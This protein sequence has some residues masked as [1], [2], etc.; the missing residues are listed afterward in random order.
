MNFSWIL[1]ILLH[2]RVS[3]TINVF[4]PGPPTGIILQNTPGLLITRC[5]LYTQRVYVCLDPWDVY[6][7][8]ISLPPR[9]TEGRPSG[10]QTHDTVERA[11]QTTVN[12]LEQLQKFLQKNMTKQQ[13]VTNT[14]QKNQACLLL[15]P[16][17][18]PEQNQTAFSFLSLGTCYNTL[19]MLRTFMIPPST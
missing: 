11:K 6:R 2:L 13:S 4:E 16:Q 14:T 17:T 10:V 15:W 5:S 7:K 1:G 3:Q 8:H 12:I 19:L 9:L 18:S